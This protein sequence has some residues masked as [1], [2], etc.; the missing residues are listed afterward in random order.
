MALVRGTLTHATVESLCSSYVFH[1]RIDIE[2]QGPITFGTAQ[3]PSDDG[4]N[5][6]ISHIPAAGDMAVARQNLAKAPVVPL[7]LFQPRQG[8]HPVDAAEGVCA[9]SLGQD[10]QA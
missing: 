8:P 9:I 6:A 4:C 10:A 1:E 3:C 2:V 7:Q 5:V